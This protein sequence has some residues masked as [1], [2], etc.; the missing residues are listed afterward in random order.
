MI[1]PEDKAQ[2][3][4]TAPDNPRR[5]PGRAG[6]EAALEM[7]EIKLIKPLRVTDEDPGGDPYNSTGRFT[8][9]D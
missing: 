8:I 9:N 1:N 7:G 5:T 3:P 4:A 6:T 2:I